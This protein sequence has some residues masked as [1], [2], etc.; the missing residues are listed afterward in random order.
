M[1]NL[2]RYSIALTTGL[3]AITA[4]VFGTQPPEVVDP[5]HC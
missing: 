3:I 5:W 2:V 1:N 4:P